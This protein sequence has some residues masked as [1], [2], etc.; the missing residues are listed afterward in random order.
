MSGISGKLIA[1]MIANYEK[2]IS[3]WTPVRERGM[4]C[5]DM[6]GTIADLYSVPNWLEK[7]RAEDAS[8]YM[9]AEPMVDMEEL[10]NVLTVLINQGWEIRV[11][12]WLS[13][14]GSKEYNAAVRKAKRAWLEKYNFPANKVHL[15][16]YGT[17]K[18]N[19]VRKQS[20]FAILIDDNQ[21][22]RDGWHLGDT[23]DPT[24]DDIIER[25]R[26]LVEG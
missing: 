15:V 9:D 2:N 23:I 7:L 10:A 26:E 1:D 4:I 21:K 5:F 14:G 25:L 12:S 3:T 17:T 13:M 8:P 18:A 20:D 11:I 19:C 6:D 24:N 16:Q 22:V